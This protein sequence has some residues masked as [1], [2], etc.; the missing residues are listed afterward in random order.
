MDKLATLL[1]CKRGSLPTSY[2]EYK[3]E[4]STRQRQ[5]GTGW[6]KD[7]KIFQVTIPLGQLGA[8]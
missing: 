3:S 5:F 2:L 6:R 8:K 7:E 4:L 1:G